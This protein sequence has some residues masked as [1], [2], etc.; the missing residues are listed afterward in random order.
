VSCAST[1]PPTTSSAP[2]RAKRRTVRAAPIR[3]VHELPRCSEQLTEGARF[4]GTCGAPL[5]VV[6]PQERLPALRGA[7][8]R[9]VLASPST[10][11]RLRPFP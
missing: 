3:I 4:C 1:N 2:R 5:E 6:V 7:G 11:G 8:N 9:Q 10:P